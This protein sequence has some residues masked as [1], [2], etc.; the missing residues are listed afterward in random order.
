MTSFEG[1]RGEP[2]AEWNACEL[3][4][5]S[6]KRIINDKLGPTG[7]E[8]TCNPG[9]RR[10]QQRLMTRSRR[11]AYMILDDVEFLQVGTQEQQSPKAAV[12]QH[13]ASVPSEM[14]APIFLRRFHSVDAD[15]S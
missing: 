13:M 1:F 11:S 4:L 10:T 3:V 15:A 2:L 7:R 14:I 6:N 9:A 8:Q 12:P 5:Q